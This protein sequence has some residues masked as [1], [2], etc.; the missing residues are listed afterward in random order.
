MAQIYIIGCNQPITALIKMLR[1]S[2]ISDHTVFV[3]TSTFVDNGAQLMNGHQDCVLSYVCLDLVQREGGQ[4][5]WDPL[6]GKS[7]EEWTMR[8][9]HNTANV[10]HFR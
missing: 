6:Q 5:C 9:L 8:R 10:P 4:T 7:E 2:I 1:V 3:Y